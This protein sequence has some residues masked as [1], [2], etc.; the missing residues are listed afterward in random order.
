MNFLM[1]DQA[2]SGFL[3]QADERRGLAIDHERTR[4][5]SP[6]A[7]N[8]AIAIPSGGKSMRRKSIW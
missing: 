3:Y 2:E 7:R 1:C 5:I 6:D 4:V 8:K